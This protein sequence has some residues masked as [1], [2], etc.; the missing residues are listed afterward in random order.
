MYEHPDIIHAELLAVGGWWAK[1]NS[2]YYTVGNVA[3]H[4]RPM[5]A[6]AGYPNVKKA[7]FPPRLGALGEAELPRLEI[8]ADK[9]YLTNLVNFKRGGKLRPLLRIVLA[10]NIKNFNKK[11]AVLGLRNIA[12]ARLISVAEDCGIPLATLKEMSTTI[13][14]DFQAQNIQGIELGAGIE[15]LLENNNTLMAQMITNLSDLNAVVRTQNQ[16]IESLETQLQQSRSNTMIMP[17]SPQAANKSSRVHQL[18]NATENPHPQQRTRGS[19]PAP[20]QEHKQQ[21]SPVQDFVMGVCR[22]VMPN[23][24]SVNNVLRRQH[25]FPVHEMLSS[26]ANNDSSPYVSKVI[27]ELVKTGQLAGRNVPYTD[28]IPPPSLFEN[29]DRGNKNIYKWAM[30]VVKKVITKEQDELF[31][32]NNMSADNAEFLVAVHAECANLDKNI[33]HWILDKEQAKETSKNNKALLY[34]IGNRAKKLGEA[35]FAETR[36]A[37]LRNIM[38]FSSKK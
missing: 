20:K 18:D 7:H 38:L 5:R 13:E 1:D 15:R 31:R 10:T 27:F 11:L 14:E 29:I 34:G 2:T 28:T 23:C 16:C 32:S 25:A 21:R 33:V 19:N 4:L 8:L 26:N 35:H 9:L 36:F 30:K 3:I 24:Q 6:L 37:D 17:A 12:V 22:S